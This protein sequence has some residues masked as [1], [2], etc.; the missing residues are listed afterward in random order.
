MNVQNIPRP[1]NGSC[2]DSTFR[3]LFAFSGLLQIIEPGGSV[4][5]LSDRLSRLFKRGEVIL[6]AQ[7]LVQPGRRP[8]GNQDG[9][10]RDRDPL[11]D[12]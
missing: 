5:R 4:L 2:N 10:E 9:P 6:A 3:F 1:N 12:K 7:C 11:Y 8:N